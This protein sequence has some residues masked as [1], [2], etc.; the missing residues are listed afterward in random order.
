M[1]GL[2]TLKTVSELHQMLGLGKPL[3]PLVTVFRQ[4]DEM[5]K[6]Y[7]SCRFASDLYL[8]TLKEHIQGSFTYGRSTYDY[9]EGTLIFMAPGQIFTAPEQKRNPGGW[10]L[11]FHHDLI[12][13]DK[14][15]E[16][17]DHYH[18]FDYEISEALHLSDREKQNVT[19]LVLKIESEIGQNLDT[20]SQELIVANIAL[21]LK[22]CSRYYDRQFYT[23]SNHN[24]D[25]TDQFTKVLKQY[26]DSELQLQRGIPT[27]KYCAAVLNI[28]A[29]YLSDLLKKE[30]GRNAQDQIQQFVISRAKNLLLN[31]D[32]TISQVAFQLGFD[33]SQHFS[34]L[35]KAKV[36][37]TPKDFRNLH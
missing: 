31:G 30:T 8:V 11:M 26:Y 7:S 23:R 17:I 3:H 15:G 22:Y 4:T 5:K 1:S 35:F 34:R 32:S 28:S 29:S 19:E 18:F 9:D 16:E 33:Y 24:H 27:V 36:G 13:T 10:T 14:L 2:K 20:H 37:Q 25:I 6:A 21:L 12:C